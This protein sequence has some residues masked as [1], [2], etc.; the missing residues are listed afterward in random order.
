MIRMMCPRC[1]KEMESGFLF[2][3]NEDGLNYADEVPGM[4]HKAKS[5]E[6]HVEIVPLRLN[7][8]AKV[9][10]CHCRDCQLVLFEY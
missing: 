4:L 1:G 3:T 5:A 9:A 8:R 2:T 7:H 10:A 6:G